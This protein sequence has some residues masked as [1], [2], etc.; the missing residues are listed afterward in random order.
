MNTGATFSPCRQYRYTLFRQWDENIPPLAFLMLNPSTADETQNDPTV[1]RCQRRAQSSGAGGVVVLNIFA[2]RSTDPKALY[3]H[4]DPIGPKND[5]SI[6]G[7]A[8]AIGSVICAWGTHGALNE[9]GK[10]V[11]S[12]LRAHD[13]KPLALKINADGS[14]AHPLYLP[15]SLQPIEMPA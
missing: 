14:P 6:V 8:G 2:L 9:R 7:V 12:W 1:E 3:S 4:A 5:E 11:L 10:T 15:Y 13:I